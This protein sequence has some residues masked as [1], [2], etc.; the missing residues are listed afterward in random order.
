PPPRPSPYERFLRI[1]I[2]A[3]CGIGVIVLCYLL[4][5]LMVYANPVIPPL[6]IAVVLVYLLNPVV[7]A[8]GRGGVPRGAGAGL[9]FLVVLCIGGL[10]VSL[11]VPVVARQVSQVIE[12]FPDYL[13]DAQ[14]YVRRGGARFGQE[15][16]F[17]LAAGPVR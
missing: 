7:T 8:R 12:H 5:R 15:P 13:A 4:L 17:R 2:T 9:V 3:W 11:L 6:L 16:N 14:G 1:G 10:I